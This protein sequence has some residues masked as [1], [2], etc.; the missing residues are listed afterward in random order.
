MVQA[1]LLL[2]LKAGHGGL[3][4]RRLSAGGRRLP[5]GLGHQLL[6]HVRPMLEEQ[7]DL[8][9][10]LGR[11]LAGEPG[12]EALGLGQV[13]DQLAPDLADLGVGHGSGRVLAAAG[14][15]LDLSGDVF[16]LGLE[17]VQ[18]SG[19]LF[20]DGLALAEFDVDRLGE[21]LSQKLGVFPLCK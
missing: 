1:L 19:A 18:G 3:V 17:A 6:K 16:V 20:P 11:L 14:Q 15:D 7:V 12:L 10:Q 2:G 21:K 5:V 8:E 4:R 13:L 9:L